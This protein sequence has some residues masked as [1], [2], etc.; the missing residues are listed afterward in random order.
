MISHMNITPSAQHHPCVFL[1]RSS[2]ASQLFHIVTQ[3]DAKVHSDGE[4]KDILVL[5]DLLSNAIIH[6]NINENRIT[7]MYQ[8]HF[9][10]ELQIILG[11]HF[12]IDH[13]GHLANE[14]TF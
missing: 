10:P 13:H 12:Q 5:I 2:Y 14:Q 1:C 9:L 6:T 3:L 11:K 8:I 7:S 4:E